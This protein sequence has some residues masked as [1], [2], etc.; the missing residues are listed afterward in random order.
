MMSMGG[1]NTVFNFEGGR[2]AKTI[3]LSR[4]KEPQIYD[5][6]KFG[7]ILENIGFQNESST[8]DYTDGTIMS[9]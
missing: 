5:V 3:D 8:L 1:R 9:T 7:A 2:Y 6:I 4:D